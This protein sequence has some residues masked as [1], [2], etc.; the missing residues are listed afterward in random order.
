MSTQLNFRVK[1]SQKEFTNRILERLNK[2]KGLTKSDAFVYVFEQYENN[3]IGNK[4]GEYISANVRDVLTQIT[5]GYIGFVNDSFIC[6]ETMMKKKEPTTLLG[7]P[8]TV[9]ENCIGCIKRKIETEQDK[10]NSEM[11]K[12][13]IKKLQAFMKEFIRISKSGFNYTAYLCLCNADE[14]KIQFSRGG[15]SMPCLQLDDESVNIQYTCME[16]INPTTQ[17]KPCEYLA[18]LEGI[19]SL[20][21]T[22]F[23]DIADVLNEESLIPYRENELEDIKKQN[24]RLGVQVDYEILKTDTEKELEESYSGECP[25]ENEENTSCI[26]PLCEYATRCDSYTAKKKWK[27]GMLK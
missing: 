12:E 15:E 13:S 19:Q 2:E 21:P 25:K 24:E 8:Q 14:G 11:R 6:R 26:M 3:I 7:E 20:D 17:N 10:R 5:C 1:D 27:K 16:K 22:I 9:L 18:S 4:S 23:K